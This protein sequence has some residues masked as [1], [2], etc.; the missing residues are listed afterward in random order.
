MPIFDL[1]CKNCEDLE[2]DVILGINERIPDCPSCGDKRVKLCNCS[3]FKLVYDNKTDICSWGNEGYATSQ[4]HR[5]TK[6]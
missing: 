2:E 1:K 4:Y 6:Q 3:H 5:H